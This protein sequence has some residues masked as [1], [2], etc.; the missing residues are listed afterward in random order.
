MNALDSLRTQL[1]AF[2]TAMRVGF[3][4]A[5]AYRAEM[6]VWMLAT[7][8]PFIMLS[9]TSAVAREAPL[10]RFGQKEFV[11]YYLMTFIVRQLTG[12][13]AAWQMNYEIRNGTMAMKLLRP[14]HPVLAYAIENVAAMPLRVVVSIPIAVMAIVI[15][16][17]SF[18]PRDWV[19][20]LMFPAAL[21][22]GWLIT[23]LANVVIGCLALFMDSSL[24]LMDAYLA[25]F[26]VFSGYLLPVETFPPFLK[27][28]TN[29][30][31]F[32]YQIGLPVELL[33]NG[34]D[35]AGA[36]ALLGRQWLWIAVLLVVGD[37]VWRRGVKRFAAYG[38]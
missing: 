22:G 11:A 7:T 12:S 33:T 30:L 26:M 28:F 9:I 29:W 31:P 37:L 3:A 36:L 2:P 32:R 5:T 35:R 10:G 34:H 6:V 8:M 27:A 17:T 16:G 13:W 25:A 20:W 14:M 24:K 19:I 4:E 23:F 1:K 38:G 15:A 21:F 18:L